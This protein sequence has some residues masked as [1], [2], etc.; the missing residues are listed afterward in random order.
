M[1][2]VSMGDNVHEMKKKKKKFFSDK[3]KKKYF[4]LSSAENFT[5]RD[6]FSANFTRKGRVQRRLEGL[7][8]TPFGLKISFSWGI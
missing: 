2:I 7:S 6:T 5:L 3:K 8:R 1:Q 4:T